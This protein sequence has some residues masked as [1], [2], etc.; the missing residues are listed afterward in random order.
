M[1]ELTADETRKVSKNVQLATNLK[2]QEL[3][4]W[5]VDLGINHHRGS[6]EDIQN[7]AISINGDKVT[8]FWHSRHYQ[9]FL[10][11]AFILR[12]PQQKEIF[13]G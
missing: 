12:T 9:K 5:L 11:K 3:V 1:K 7:G 4:T 13:P 6:Q 10:G 8:D 2:E